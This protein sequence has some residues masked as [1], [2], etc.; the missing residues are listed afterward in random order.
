MSLVITHGGNNTVCETF[1]FGK[2]IIVMPMFSDQ[3]DNA[4]R[5][6]EKGFGI[7]M[8]PFQCTKDQLLNGINKL[9]N[10]SDLNLKMKNIS[11]RFKAEVKLG[12]VGQLIENLVS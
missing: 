11:E 12:K 10:D 3:F 4:Q 6:Q 7:R 9:I 2:P 8:N 1:Y 5:I